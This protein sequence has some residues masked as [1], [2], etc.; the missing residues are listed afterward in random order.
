[1]TLEYVRLLYSVSYTRKYMFSR[2]QKNTAIRP[3]LTVFTL[4]VSE[5]RIN[6]ETLT[7]LLE[8]V[9]KIDER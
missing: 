3:Y 1:M 5:S 2:Y 9:L 7:P 8:Y 4:Y 6:D